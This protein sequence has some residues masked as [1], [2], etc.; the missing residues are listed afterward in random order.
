[1]GLEFPALST[2][3]AERQ[4]QSD[5]VFLPV[6]PF[7]EGKVRGVTAEGALRKQSWRVGAGTLTT[8]QILAPL[9]E[10]LENAGYEVLFECEAAICGGFDFRFELETFPEPEMHV[11][12]GD[13]RYLAAQK[14]V[15]GRPEYASLIISR[16]GNAGFVQLTQVGAAAAPV[17][18]TASTKAP[19]TVT[20]NPGP[21]GEQLEATGHATLDDLV[22]KTGRSELGDTSFASLTALADYLKTRPDRQVVLVGHT[23]SEGSLQ[24]NV[25]LS[26][27]RAAAVMER[28]IG[29]YG[30]PRSQVAADGVGFLSPIASNLT[31]EGRARNRR[32]EVILTSTQ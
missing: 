16:S 29:S 31:P 5:S 13:Y 8:L 6:G 3:L 15:E 19:A 25:A 23:D 2:S 14:I 21:V 7:S 30:V 28:L 32:V 17:R 20:V 26:K 24:G 4:S 1:M 12:L 22:F 10:Q 11:A 27:R 18:V 9:R